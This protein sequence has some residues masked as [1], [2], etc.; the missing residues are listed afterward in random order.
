VEHNDRWLPWTTAELEKL[1]LKVTPSV[2]NFILIHFPTRPKHSAGKG[3]RPSD[4]ARLHPAPRI[5][6]WLPERAAH[7]D[8]HR[9]GQSRRRRGARRIPEELTMAEPLF[10]RIAL[11]GI[12]LIGSS[13][14]RVIR[15][16]KLARH[17]AISTR[18]K[19]RR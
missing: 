4:G 13:L 6:L 3:R 11:I 19:K 12:G 5:R 9:R 18:S 10:D 2:G 14:A 8:R 17:V 16:E 1:G 15:R 7:D